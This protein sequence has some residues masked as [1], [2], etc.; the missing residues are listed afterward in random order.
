MKNEFKEFMTSDRTPPHTLTQAV[1]NRIEKTIE[2]PLG[3]VMPRFLG[4]N[5]AVA[6]LTLAVCPQFG[7]GPIGG[8]HGIAAFFMD[9]NMTACALFCGGFFVG[10]STLIAT[11][12]LNPLEMKTIYRSSLWLVPVFTF[13][14]LMVL[15]AAGYWYSGG[16]EFFTPAFATFWA[17]G[18]IIT[19][20]LF[21]H[22]KYV[23]HLRSSAGLRK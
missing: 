6:L 22:L 13:V 5:I 15:M 14:A 18:A 4:V 19:S 2:P 7:I 23:I 11:L 8:G 12:F 9:I 1:F 20:R 3:Q 10:F 16:N 17:L 21:L